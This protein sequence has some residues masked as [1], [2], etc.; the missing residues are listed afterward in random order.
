MDAFIKFITGNTAVI[1]DLIL[2]AMLVIEGLYQIISKKMISYGSMLQKY[3]EESVRRFA[4]PSGAMVI[5]EGIG[6][7]LFAF[8]MEGGPLPEYVHW[9]GLTLMLISL[10]LYLVMMKI[11]LVKKDK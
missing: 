8:G 9:I 1:V 3:T 7:F 6:V 5:L 2:M 10:V 11:F 4:C